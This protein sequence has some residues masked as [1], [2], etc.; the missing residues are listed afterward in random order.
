MP[1]DKVDMKWSRNTAAYAIIEVDPR[2]IASLHHV[3]VCL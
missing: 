2:G 1:I 3:N